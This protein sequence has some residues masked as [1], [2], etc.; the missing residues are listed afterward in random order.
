M[1]ISYTEFNVEIDARL[2]YGVDDSGRIGFDCARRNDYCVDAKGYL[3]AFDLGDYMSAPESLPNEATVWTPKDV[4]KE[5]ERLAKQFGD[6]IPYL[7][8]KHA[9]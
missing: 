7:E 3:L 6:S 8:E 1:N 4:F 2:R 5:T 9:E